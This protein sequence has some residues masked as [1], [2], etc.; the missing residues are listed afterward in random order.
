MRKNIALLR[1][2]YGGSPEKW[3]TEK[4][5]KMVMELE[6]VMERMGLYTNNLPK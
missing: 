1:F 4:Y 5:C 6:Y 2:H 3:S